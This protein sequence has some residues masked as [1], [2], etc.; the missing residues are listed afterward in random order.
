MDGIFFAISPIVNG[1]PAN[2]FSRRLPASQSVM[3]V[4][5]SV[6]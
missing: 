6:K 1:P 2:L 3:F 4:W 5:G